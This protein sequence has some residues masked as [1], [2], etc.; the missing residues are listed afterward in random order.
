MA[1]GSVI[2][3]DGAERITF[4]IKFLDGGGRQVMETVP[5]A[6]VK[7][8]ATERQIEAARKKA[9]RELARRLDKAEAGWRKPPPITFKAAIGE[10]YDAMQKEKGWKQ[11]TAGV[12]LAVVARL[13]E[14]FGPMALARVQAGDV[15]AYKATKLEKYGASTVSRDLSI[16]HSFFAWA[17][18]A[19]GVRP[20]PT[21]GVPHPRKPKWRGQALKP[22]EVQA[23]LRSFDDEQAR[24]VFLTVVLT[25][26]RCAEMQKLGWSDVDL[27]E[28]RLRVVDSKT[29][30]GERSIA[31]PPMLAEELW[32]W[33][34]RTNY[35]GDGDRVFCF[36]ESGGVYR[37]DWF[38]DALLRACETAGVA[39]P[40][41]FRKLHDL[42]VTS[43]TN[44]V[45]ANEHG[46][47]LQ[48]RAGHA[49]FST[50]QRYI[51]LAGVVFHEE[52]EELER[53]MLGLST[54]SST[55]LA[56][57]EPT[58]DNAASLNDAAAA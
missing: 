14:T 12:Y 15:V 42:R 11:S 52:A 31:L 23:I 34:R 7:K 35:R 24:V 56:S 3:Y 18:V 26:I 10:W 46:S 51:D 55:R 8:G 39:L 19:K 37:P 5:D 6:S 58:S 54:E 28:N 20:N 16:L 30:T 45:R 13:N 21:E 36:Q 1:S 48:A 41:G 9:E 27:I 53:R 32:Q 44:G 2:R 25:G 47:K 40:A 17:A 43:I 33:R 57:P 22:E 50:T 49:N 38:K 4:R 29:K